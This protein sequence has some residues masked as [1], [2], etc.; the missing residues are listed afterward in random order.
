MY[1]CNFSAQPKLT[2]RCKSTIIKKLKIKHFNAD[3]PK[4]TI[5]SLKKIVKD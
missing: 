5:V 4:Q 2:E 1:N 3:K